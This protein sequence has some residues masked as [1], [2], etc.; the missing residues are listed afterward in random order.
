MELS[1]VTTKGQVT[2]PKALREAVGATEG[3]QIGWAVEG[4]RLVGVVVPKPKTRRKRLLPMPERM[5]GPVAE[6]VDEPAFP[7]LEA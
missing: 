7:P 6:D 4:G 3:D 5:R 1:T 2:I